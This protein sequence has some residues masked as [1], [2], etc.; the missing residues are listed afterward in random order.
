MDGID[1]LLGFLAMVVLWGAW[2][3][4]VLRAAPALD[5]WFA[6]KPKAFRK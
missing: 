6:P 4:V 3:A 2:T 5:R 1:V